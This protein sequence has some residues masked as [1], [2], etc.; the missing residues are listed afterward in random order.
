MSTKLE[1]VVDVAKNV[2]KT[3]SLAEASI[4]LTETGLGNSK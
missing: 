2:F 4:E 3:P 1:S